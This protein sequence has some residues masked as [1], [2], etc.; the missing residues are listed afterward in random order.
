MR[1]MKNNP[2]S[3]PYVAA[4]Y[5][6]KTGDYASLSLVD[7]KVI[8]LA[9][10]LQEQFNPVAFKEASIK[11]VL[12]SGGSKPVEDTNLPVGFYMPKLNLGKYNAHFK[13]NSYA[14]GFCFSEQDI[15][16]Y[17]KLEGAEIGEDLVYL[18]RWIN[19]VESLLATASCREDYDEGSDKELG[20][21]VLEEEARD[22]GVS[23]EE[24]EEAE[25]SDESDGGG[26]ITPSN[27][28]AKRT[29]TA[30][31]SPVGILSTDFA[32]QVSRPAIS[33]Y[34]SNEPTW[35][36]DIGPS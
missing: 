21:E 27:Y 17:R 2:N 8:A 29:E 35:T 33:Q 1:L 20:D 26:W 28:K 14:Q 13:T 16:L 18:K 15:K 19:H 23:G 5:A 22:S 4:D 11:T 36:V 34:N 24:D 3:P 10:Q 30:V 9:I 6:K 7:I 12:G 25:E 32:I 31:S